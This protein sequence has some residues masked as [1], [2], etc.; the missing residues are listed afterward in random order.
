MKKNSKSIIVKELNDIVYG[1]FPSI[2]K[3]AEALNCSTKTVY[4]SLKSSSKLL[5]R[6]WIVNYI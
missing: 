5:K 4:R 1:E 6:R 2:V 3:T